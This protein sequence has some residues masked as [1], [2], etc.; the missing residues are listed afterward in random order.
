[1]EKVLITGIAG[2]QG[3][4]LT[5]RLMQDVEVCGADIVR[6]KG[7]PRGV[8]VHAVDL[9]KKAFED[10]IRTE[11]PT[12]IVHMGMIRGFDKGEAARHDVNVRG[13]KKLLDHCVNHGVQKLV[14][15]S[16]SYV[17]G[18]FPENP[19]H[20][21]EDAPLSASRSY[22]EIRDLVEVDTLASAFIWKYP[23]IRTAVL[24]PVN[25]LGRYVHSMASRFLRQQRVPVVLGFNP[26]M[27]FIHEEDLT[28][29]I[30]LTLE[31]GLQ[32]VFNVV[33]A[34]EVPVRTAIEEVGGTAIPVPEPILRMGFDA[35]FGLGLL[36]FPSG[37]LDYL[38]YPVT[39]SGQRF[40][41]ATDFRCL[42]G[43]PEIFDSVRH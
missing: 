11:Q 22:P 35:A 29:A 13:T 32:G 10:V 6:W 34:G 33:G 42:F 18:A 26:M 23:H 28:E 20:L 3:R 9:R 41:E 1:M 4:L 24:R 37:M 19:Y 16:S 27:Q 38:K 31:Q 30:A 12:A 5:R 40:V 15:L 2:G 17:Y 21:D 8:T 39:L 7:R 36:P 43:L 25:V 14:V